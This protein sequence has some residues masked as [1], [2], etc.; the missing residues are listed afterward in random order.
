MEH[1]QRERWRKRGA[2]CVVKVPQQ[3]KPTLQH[4]YKLYQKGRKH[5]NSWFS[6][7]TVMKQCCPSVLMI[8]KVCPL[9]LQSAVPRQPQ[10]VWVQ[11]GQQHRGSVH[12]QH[13]LLRP[14]HHRESTSTR[15]PPFFLMVKYCDN[16]KEWHTLTWGIKTID[17]QTVNNIKKLSWCMCWH[18]KSA[19][20]YK[21]S[22]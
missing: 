1:K 14:R 10:C 13:R 2:Q 21:S 15:T 7:I 20:E 17:I 11:S 22:V 19:R 8:W 4:S 6:V 5:H 9:L 18:G 3:P 16:K 12:R